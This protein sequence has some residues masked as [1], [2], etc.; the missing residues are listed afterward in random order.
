MQ[1]DNT[2]L[3]DLGIFSKN[4][5]ESILHLLNHTKTV[6]GKDWLKFFIKNPHDQINKILETQAII[7]KFIEIGNRF[8]D[9]I[10][11][12]T[13]MV[14]D[15]YYQSPVSSIPR[16]A[17]KVE[18]WFYTAF[19]RGDY[20]IL[21]YSINHIA[22]FIKGMYELV[23][24]LQDENSI[25]PLQQMLSQAQRILD[26]PLFKRINTQNPKKKLP[27][28]III[29]VGYY[30]YQVKNDVRELE[31]IFYKIDAWQSL[32]KACVIHKFNFPEISESETPYIEAQN[33][34]HPLLQDPVGYDFII[35]KE[36][37][38]MFLTG[39]NMAGKST[40]IRAV[41]IAVYLANIG[42][43][44]P[45][46]T[47]KMSRFDGLLSNIDISDNTLKGE[48][49]FYNE[50]QRIN[51]TVSK[52]TDGKNWLILID[53]LFKGTNIQDA[54][55]CSTVVIEGFRKIDNALFILST[56]L[57][58][59]GDYLKKYS[60]IQFKYFE[61]EVGADDYLRFSYKLR[62]GISNDRLGYLILKR[63]G[64]IDK[65]NSLGE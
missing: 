57:Y 30:L 40:F 58:E 52:I 62:D 29:A 21:R 10:T 49:Y 50:V 6:G 51:K 61:T 20:L 14:L 19:S 1:I 55:R 22:T 48:S 35:A 23:D 11:N 41:G 18:A 27:A 13:M 36:N 32:A 38:F 37:N 43:G 8:P 17:G 34:W 56:H 54:M 59:I 16:S 12:G 5:E 2:T 25:L 4:E 60:N 64:V 65:L 26:K 31:N 47:I 45:A 33:L 9:T 42:I 28:K 7:K 3:A 24:L 44:V 53:E 46:N 63:E 15:K 39:A